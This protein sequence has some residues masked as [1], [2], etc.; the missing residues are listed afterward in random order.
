M[1]AQASESMLGTVWIT[2][3]DDKGHCLVQANQSL[4]SA[5]WEFVQAYQSLLGTVW[6]I[7]QDD[8]AWCRSISHC[9]A[10]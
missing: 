5:I 6:I 4:L 1:F 10:L 9:L 8:K 3:Q 7:V 2:V